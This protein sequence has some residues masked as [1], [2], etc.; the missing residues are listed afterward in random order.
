MKIKECAEIFRDSEIVKPLMRVC[1]QME[2]NATTEDKIKDV[3]NRE[4]KEKLSVFLGPEGWVSFKYAAAAYF[5]CGKE[6]KNA[7]KQNVVINQ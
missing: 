6:W 2:E 4:E 5:L 3:L 7:Q 1:R